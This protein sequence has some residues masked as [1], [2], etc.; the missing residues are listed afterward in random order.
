MPLLQNVLKEIEHLLACF[1]IQER[2]HMALLWNHGET[3]FD[4]STGQRFF[5]RSAAGDWNQHVA[6]AM[7]NLHHRVTGGSM[8]CW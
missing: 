4:P 1:W 6:F 8:D 5:Q 3:D 2:Q 7:D